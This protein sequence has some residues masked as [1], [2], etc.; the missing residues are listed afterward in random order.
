MAQHVDPKAIIISERYNFHKAQ[1]EESET[2]RQY[3]PTL[4]KWAE[5][6]EFRPYREEAIGDGLFCGLRSHLQSIQ[7]KLLAEATLTL[8]TTVEKAF[9]S[10]VT[11]KEASG[12][13]C[14][15][16]DIKKVEET[17][18]ECFNCCKT[19]HSQGKCFHRKAQCMDAKNLAT[20]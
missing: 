4:Q 11:E 3:L 15:S 5:T 7:G 12:F 2:V 6:C 8:Q 9:A 1:Q 13:H 19:D 17:F 10:E 20:S 14:S 16:C 18:P